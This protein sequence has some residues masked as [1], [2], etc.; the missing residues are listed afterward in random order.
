MCDAR[1]LCNLNI[2]WSWHPCIIP[3]DCDTATSSGISMGDQ[4]QATL[5]EI[6]QRRMDA[7]KQRLST[8]GK[9]DAQCPLR[10]QSLRERGPA[11]GSSRPQYNPSGNDMSITEVLGPF[12]EHPTPSSDEQRWR[13][14]SV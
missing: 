1:S 4:R 8:K 2:T 14:K 11:D 10:F 6:G 9:D 3:P 5:C 12:D 7:L 13:A